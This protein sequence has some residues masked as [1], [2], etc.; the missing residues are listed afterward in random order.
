[1]HRPVRLAVLLSG[2]G[3]TL[4]NF[5][6]RIDAGTLSAQVVH[7]VGSLRSAYGLER[8]RQ[9]SIP[10]SVIRRRDYEDTEAFSAAIWDCVGAAAP[11]LVAL[12]GFMC[13]VTIPAGFLG[14]VMNIHPA[15]LP[16]FGGKGMYGH[17]VHEAVLSYGCKI[18]GCTVHFVDNEY[19]RGPII[20]Q[21]S[22]PVLEGDVPD[23][24]AARVFEQECEAYPE[25]INLFAQGRLAIRGRRVIIAPPS[26]E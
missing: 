9:R 15:L 6:D 12:A 13:H 16:S 26:N 17:H 4:Q 24:L 5:L 3:R 25:A 20:I 19:D 23:T 2:S 1:M 7:V 18:S 14:R 8:A 22:V 21:R 10:A 11:D